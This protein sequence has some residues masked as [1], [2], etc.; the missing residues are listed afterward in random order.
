[1][2][3]VSKKSEGKNLIAIIGD[4][5]TMGKH[6]G[7][8]DRVFVDGNRIKK[9]SW[10]MQLSNHWRK[11]A[12]LYT[13][14]TKTDVENTFR[15]FLKDNDISVILITQDASEKYVKSMITGRE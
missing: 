5:V 4:E 13:E 12:L 7:Y 8:G 14:T 1:M 11:Y 9:C 10:G 3:A 15:R 2:K 6:V